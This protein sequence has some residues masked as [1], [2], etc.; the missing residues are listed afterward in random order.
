MSM[1]PRSLVNVAHLSTPIIGH[2]I[3][4]RAVQN[5]SKSLIV[6]MKATKLESD[7]NGKHRVLCK[8]LDITTNNLE[9]FAS[10]N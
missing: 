4:A 1:R 5:V 3:C 2:S 6:Y 9:F 10:D 7:L 8:P